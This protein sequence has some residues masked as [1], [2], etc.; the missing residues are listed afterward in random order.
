M[1]SF[2]SLLA[3]QETEKTAPIT[4]EVK[5]VSGAVTP[6]AHIKLLP[7][8]GALAKEF[9]TD[10]KGRLHLSLS[11][12]SYDVEVTYPGFLH[13]ARRIEVQE[14]KSQIV[15][16]TLDVWSGSPIG[17]FP[18]GVLLVTQALTR[19][20]G[21]QIQTI[22]ILPIGETHSAALVLSLAPSFH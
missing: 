20:A 15:T 9:D 2:C 7:V 18:A 10:Y 12:G 1:L 17:P 14:G 8:S 4:F 16:V 22:T 21:T 19:G 3:A 11:P 13:D 5:D 6:G